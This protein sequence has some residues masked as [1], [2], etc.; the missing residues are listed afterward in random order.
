MPEIHGSSTLAA[1]EYDPAAR[2]LSLR[3]VG[4]R[5]Y[6]YH[7]ASQ[8][9]VDE[10]ATAESAGRFFAQRIKGRL[11]CLREGEPDPLPE[12]CAAY[13]GGEVVVLYRDADATVAPDQSI[14]PRS[15]N[16]ERGVSAAQVAAMVAGC[17]LGWSH[18][19]A[20]PSQYDE[21]TAAGQVYPP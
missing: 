11:R 18:F 6:R 14:V 9:L 2:V 19:L 3:F 21:A 15:W 1:Y 13:L 4:G 5:A 16:E 8:D 17:T 20:D 12:V 7:G 10:L